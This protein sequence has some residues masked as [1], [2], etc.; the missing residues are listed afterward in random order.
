M[1]NEQRLSYL[2]KL[3]QEAYADLHAT[4]QNYNDEFVKSMRYME[5]SNLFSVPSSDSLASS[6]STSSSEEEQD[7]ISLSMQNLVDL[8]EAG[9][10]KDYSQLIEWESFTVSY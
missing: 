7:D 10:I 2:T 6:S 9:T 4:L 1:A 3:R 5:E 8:F